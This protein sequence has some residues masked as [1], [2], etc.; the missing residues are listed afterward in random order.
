MQA[1]IAIVGVL[2]ALGAGAWQAHF[3]SIFHDIGQ[4]GRDIRAINNDRCTVLD[5]LPACES[6][7]NP[8]GHRQ[9]LRMIPEIVLHQPTGLLFMACSTTASRVQWTPAL[10]RLNASAR[11]T[12][13]Y[14]AIFDPGSRSTR[15]LALSG[16]SDPRGLN[17]HGMDVVP[18]STSTSELFVY[19]V[20]QRPPLAQM[21]ADHAD[22]PHSSVEIFRMNAITASTLE[23]V[24]TVDSPLI[25]SPNDVAGS[26]D[27]KSFWLT[28]D[29]SHER[30][31]AVCA[32]AAHAILP[33]SLT[34][35]SQH[36]AHIWLKT[37]P[38]NVVH[39]VLGGGCKVAAEKLRGA[40]GIVRAP[41]TDIF[42]VASSAGRELRA[43]ERQADDT[44]VLT[45][46]IDAGKSRTVK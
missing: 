18:S 9:L 5:E 19:F 38:T 7:C 35:L 37:T 46:V 4:L 26:P 1:L 16:F 24:A 2:V 20:N 8:T 12:T 44:L 27:G 17:T 41:G 23:H 10:H 33:C 13:D 32:V 31:F 14:V 40:N 30:G 6:K 3:K 28:N 29:G 39:C 15:K 22:A 43:F 45:D 21:T 34:R 25:R 11:S 36:H 42:Y